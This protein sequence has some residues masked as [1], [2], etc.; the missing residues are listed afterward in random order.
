MASVADHSIGPSELAKSLA[1]TGKTDIR[2]SLEYEGIISPLFKTVQELKADND[3][4]RRD[5]DEKIRKLGA[6]IEQLK[7]AHH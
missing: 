3:N 4:I 7:A 5:E 1:E 6:E 2:Y